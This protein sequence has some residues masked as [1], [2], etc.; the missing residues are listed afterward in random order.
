[1]QLWSFAHRALPAWLFRDP[2]RFFGILAGPDRDRFIADLW[3][4][5]GAPGSSASRHGFSFELGTVG[6]G[7]LLTMTFAPTEERPREI[8]EPYRGVVV[9]KFD[10]AD[11][12]RF[13]YVRYFLLE[14][15]IDVRAE[16][17]IT[18]L[19]EHTADGA[20]HNHGASV[21]PAEERPFVEAVYELL[22]LENERAYS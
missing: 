21:P 6:N 4:K 12:M 9:A 20:H 1:V 13:L 2:N 3:A 10:P 11:R 16:L 5:C 8:G 15:G 19:C 14:H 17:P 22:R 7:V 18:M